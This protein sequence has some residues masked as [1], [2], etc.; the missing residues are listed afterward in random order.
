MDEVGAEVVCELC[1][2]RLGLGLCQGPHC[3]GAGG[4]CLSVWVWL[5]VALTLCCAVRWAGRGEAERAARRCSSG[6]AT[7]ASVRLGLRR[8]WRSRD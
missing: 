4:E 1:E 8:G 2:E 6:K 7:A 5:L 3:C